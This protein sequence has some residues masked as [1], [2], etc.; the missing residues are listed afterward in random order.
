MTKEISIYV[1]VFNGEKTIKQCLDSIFNQTLIPNKILVINDNS[2]DN[3]KKILHDY[4]NDIRVINNEK[5][6]GL[7]HSRFLA[8][9]YLKTKYIASI[10]AD[11]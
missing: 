11:E 3:T 7:S 2:T 5:N 1:P 8:V 4:G 6:E 9:N 10:D